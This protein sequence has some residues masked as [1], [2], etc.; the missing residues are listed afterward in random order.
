MSRCMQKINYSINDMNRYNFLLMWLFFLY[1]QELLRE[2][3]AAIYFHSRN[4]LLLLV[5]SSIHLPTAFLFET[6]TCPM[7]CR[8]FRGVHHC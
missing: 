5:K 3:Y 2:E 4:A 6:T 8:E 7:C 1:V